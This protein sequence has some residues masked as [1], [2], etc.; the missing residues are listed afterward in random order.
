M[1]DLEREVL[2][3][4]SLASTARRFLEDGMRYDD[5]VRQLEDCRKEAPD[6]SEYWLARELQ[7]LL[8]YKTWEGFS[9][10]IGRAMTAAKSAGLEPDN[11]FR[12]T[13]KMVGIGSGAERE[14]VDWFLSR[15]G[16]Y[17]IA[18]NSDPTKE[19]VGH[20]QTYFAIQTRIQE[21][22]QQSLSDSERLQMR[23]R[24]RDANTGLASLAKR[25]GVRNF[26]VFHDRGY[27]GLYG[28]LG[29]GEIKAR[30]NI[31]TKDDL[32]DCVGHTELAANYF[33][34]TQARERIEK[35][36]IND[37]GRANLAHQEAGAEVRR[38]MIKISG[39]K[40][41][42]LPSATN[43]KRLRQAESRT[44]LASADQQSDDNGEA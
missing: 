27:K 10:A 5:Y 36:G 33:R 9:D 41:E 7:L 15:Y 20:A 14:Q 39:V 8:G 29:V 1:R 40:P 35:Y 26:A 22:F 2:L 23:E 16:C 43:L 12:R 19:E 18:M 38:S 24:V 37:E 17:V 25:V 13:S 34:I 21:Q 44:L 28:G 31:P 6:S 3:E 11:H 4:F 42:D 30:K 32:L